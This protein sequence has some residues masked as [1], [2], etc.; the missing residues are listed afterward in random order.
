MAKSRNRK[1]DKRKRH[2][3]KLRKV[4]AKKEAVKVRNT[5]NQ[6]TAKVQE[7]V[8]EKYLDE[9]APFTKQQFDYLLKKSHAA[10]NHPNG[11]SNSK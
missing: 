8:N 11:L 10:T 2:Y 1:R 3:E 9:T 6:M 4:H 5:I 7:E